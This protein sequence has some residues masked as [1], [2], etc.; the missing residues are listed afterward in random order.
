MSVLNFDSLVVWWR[1]WNTQM[2][3]HN[4]AG[5]RGMES[6]HASGSYRHFEKYRTGS[7]EWL[8]LPGNITQKRRGGFCWKEKILWNKR[9]SF[10]RSARVVIVVLL[11]PLLLLSCGSRTHAC[12]IVLGAAELMLTPFLTPLYLAE[13]TLQAGTW[14]WGRGN[15]QWG[16]S[17]L[18]VPDFVL[19]PSNIAAS[20]CLCSL[21]RCRLGSFLQAWRGFPFGW[22]SSGSDMLLPYLLLLLK[23]SQLG[24]W[25]S[26]T[27]LS[28]KRRPRRACLS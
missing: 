2:K 22:C 25:V 7:K 21:A 24:P 18:Q 14:G 19:L 26:K 15:A 6:N 11:G 4:L 16:Q 27:H 28:R 9:R 17:W 8:G 3:T 12:R 20:R 1:L 5:E 23:R 10:G 13:P